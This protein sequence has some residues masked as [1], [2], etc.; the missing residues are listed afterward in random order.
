MNITYQ[1]IFNL[2][3]K[4]ILFLGLGLLFWEAGR[5]LWKGTRSNKGSQKVLKAARKRKYWGRAVY[6]FPEAAVMT[7]PGLGD[8]NN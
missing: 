3:A 5:G 1:F 8:L 7:N 2:E 6:L 4:V